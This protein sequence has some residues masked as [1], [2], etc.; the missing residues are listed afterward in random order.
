M[1]ERCAI[2]A[3]QHFESDLEPTAAADY[4]PGTWFH[5]GWVAGCVTVPM[6]PPCGSVWQEGCAETWGTGQA[7]R[8]AAFDDASGE[9]GEAA[10]DEGSDV[11]VERPPRQLHL[12]MAV[13]EGCLWYL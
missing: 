7:V 8:A 3:A 11:P 2:Q 12:L 1:S 13:A 10:A 9:G 6:E 5:T 4:P